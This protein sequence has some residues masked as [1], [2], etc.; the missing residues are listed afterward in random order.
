MSRDVSLFSPTDTGRSNAEMTRNAP[1]ENRIKRL[2]AT[3]IVAL[4]VIWYL[5]AAAWPPIRVGL[6]AGWLLMPTILALSLRWPKLRY[7][8]MVPALLVAGSLTAICLTE[9]SPDER[10]Q[11]GWQLVAGGVWLGGFMGMWFWYRW[12][13]VPKILDDPF[14]RGRWLFVT[15]HVAMIVAGIVLLGIAGVS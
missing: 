8:L 3:S 6:G 9:A 11:I 10:I 14:S 15:V 4:G 13:P 12:L 5:A 7:A 2:A 1:F